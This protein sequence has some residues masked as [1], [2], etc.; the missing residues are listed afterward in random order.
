MKSPKNV[1][2][3]SAILRPTEESVI[4][5]DIVKA[6]VSVADNVSGDFG[7]TVTEL[8][9]KVHSQEAYKK[10][11]YFQVQSLLRIRTNMYAL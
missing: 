4:T 8:L 11:R 7:T 3:F 5:E 2:S 1:L 6:A 10:A 9:D